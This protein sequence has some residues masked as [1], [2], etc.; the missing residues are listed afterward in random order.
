MRRA[1]H[2]FK[3]CAKTTVGASLFAKAQCQS[4]KVLNEEPLSR[5]GSLPQGNSVVPE[6]FYQPRWRPRK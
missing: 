1:L 5:E 6:G 2:R 4:T 3:S